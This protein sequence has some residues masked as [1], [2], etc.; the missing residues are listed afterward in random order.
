MNQAGKRN[1][2]TIFPNFNHSIR[3]DF[4]GTKISLDTGVL[5]LQETDERFNITAPLEDR[6]VD[7]R[8]AS[9]LR[10][11]YVDLIHQRVYQMAAGHEDCN[12]ASPPRETALA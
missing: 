11:T 3:I 2:N 1:T 8:L 5:M 6:V 9:H 7:P 4:R 10:H 12:S